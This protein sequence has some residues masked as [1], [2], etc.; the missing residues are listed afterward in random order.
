MGKFLETP[1]R[2]PHN[3]W[4]QQP[5]CLHQRIDLFDLFLIKYPLKEELHVPGPHLDGDAER[6][7]DEGH[8][9]DQAVL[10]KTRL[11]EESVT[12]C[13]HRIAFLVAGDTLSDGGIEGSDGLYAMCQGS[14]VHLRSRICGTGQFRGGKGK[15][16]VEEEFILFTQ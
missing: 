15:H 7:P 5:C 14:R 6:A 16:G 11:E 13:E 8:V 9:L 1:T 10:E 3:L 12:G 2:R 4:L